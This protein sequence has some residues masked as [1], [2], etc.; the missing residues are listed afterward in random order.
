MPKKNP[1]ELLQSS[2][3]WYFF[4]QRLRTWIVPE[5]E[6]PYRPFLSLIFNLS[7]GTI[8]GHDIGTSPTASNAK[9][10]LFRAMTKPEAKM[11]ENPERP[12]RI[13]FEDEAWMTALRL[14]LQE[15]GVECR[16]RP[17]T[18]LSRELVAELET[19]MRGD[20]PVI[21]GLLRQKRVNPPLIGALFEA[22]AEFY[23]AAPW[24]QLGNNHLL[25]LSVSSQKEPYYATVMGQGGVEYGLGVYQTWEQVERQYGD[26]DR[27]RDLLG[28]EERHVF[29]FNE[30]TQV[31]FDD[32]DALETYQWAVA[33]P[34]A[35]PVPL[36]FI[37]PDEIRRPTR[38]ELLWYE[39]VMR[40]IPRFVQEHLT[41]DSAGQPEPAEAH[42][43]VNT[44]AGK[45]N[46]TIKYPGGDLPK[47]RA[48]SLFDIESDFDDEDEFSELP[49]DRRAMEGD[50]AHWVADLGESA[51]DAK[52][53]EAQ[54]LMYEAWDEH[55][56]ARRLALAHQALKISPDCA[57]AYVLLAEEEAASLQQAH[58]LYRQ[59]VE[60]G[61]R[62]LGETYFEENAGHFWGLLET[63]PYMRSLEGLASTLWESGRREEALAAYREL[64]R[65]NPGDNQGIRYVLADLLLEL[66][67]DAELGTLLE[68]YDNDASAVWSYSRALYL[69][70][71]A[72]AN[73]KATRALRQALEQNPYVLRYLIA[74]VRIPN[75]LPDFIGFGE[76]SEAQVY[77]AH[78]LNYWRRSPGA[79]EWLQKHAGVAKKALKK[80]P[81]KSRRPKSRF[82]MGDTVQVRQG[83]K[84]PDDESVD[85]DGWQ[86][87]IIEIVEEQGEVLVL[88]AWD[89]ETLVQIP[90]ASI[91]ASMGEGYDCS[92]MYLTEEVLTPAKPRSVE[93]D[94]QLVIERLEREHAWGY[95]GA[96]GIRIREVLQG[97]DWDDEQAV[98]RAWDSHLRK[99]LEL[100][101]EAEVTEELDIVALEID[102]VVKVISFAPFDDDEGVMVM[103]E[104]DNW[105]GVVPLLDLEP[106]D[107]QS[108]NYRHVD[109]YLVWYSEI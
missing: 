59:G 92:A 74:E 88:V 41:L 16:L 39:A 15:I 31:P 44:Y 40:A 48:T 27:L 25:S 109:D 34:Q 29:F 19:Y 69:F 103:V 78:H 104:K 72:G 38:E 86:G 26:Y 83:V 76:E 101:F 46:V 53:S 68:A 96:Q 99:V 51:L 107:P 45:V 61:R 47:A 87:E 97:V 60:A 84:D 8:R 42:I 24:V 7:A 50:M 6:P 85:L 37:L 70:R 52:T 82:R 30:I 79:L 23:R 10:M 98:H 12:A 77:A 9:K 57:D 62:A 2:A 95:L 56:P 22:A 58:D 66:N 14:A 108:S 80:K 32:L 11:D 91:E 63:R 28:S 54:A 106:T 5:D 100:P 89:A 21:P 75:M 64:I 18:D 1:S 93:E 90:P 81:K 3:T 94:R 49:F 36:I 13:F 55:N 20:R 43:P 4:V 105:Q 35:Y 65:L 33:G 73:Q 71:Q 67:Q 102:D 17:Q